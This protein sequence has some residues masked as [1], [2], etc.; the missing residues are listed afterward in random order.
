MK[1]LHIAI[2]DLQR[3]FRSLVGIGMMLVAPL[4]ITGLIYFAFS[5]LSEGN[6]GQVTDFR[7][8]VVNQDQPP[9][10]TD[11]LGDLLLAFLQDERMPAFLKISRAVDQQTALEAVSQQQAEAALLIPTNFSS[12]LH[13][14]DTLPALTLVHDPAVTMGPQILTSLIGQFMDG[15][16]G[17][18]ILVES[19][20]AAR[21]LPNPGSMQTAISAY[22]D[23]YASFQ[24]SLLHSSNPTIKFT[25]AG[26][27]SGSSQNPLAGIFGKTM[28]G[29][30]IF[31]VFFSGANGAQAILKEEEEKTLARIFTTPTN[32]THIL[33]GSYLAIWLTILV[34]SVVLLTASALIFDI[35]WGDLVGLAVLILGLSLAATGFGL[36]LISFMKNSRQA[37]VAIGGVLVIL[38]FFGGLFTTGVANLPPAFETVTLFTPHGWALRAFNLL[39]AG[40][41]V[42]QV[43]LPATV[44][45]AMGTAFFTLG[46]LRFNRRLAMK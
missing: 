46:A 11:H 44:L 32:R 2:K 22:T 21:Q 9:V 42:S 33:A 13:E 19:M 28:A 5:G 39:L 38:G 1:I 43:L 35:P 31:F 26:A 29:M 30:L 14:P 23:W 10:G 41:N 15:V 7:V 37:G 8:L 40:S 3:S 24:T 20:Q 25:S 34:Q 4:L 45:L 18:V 16:N 12:S 36:A 27:G 17:A 6:T